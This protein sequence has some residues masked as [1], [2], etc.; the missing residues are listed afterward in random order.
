MLFTESTA[1]DTRL[2]IISADISVSLTHTLKQHIESQTSPC[3]IEI[4]S[5]SQTRNGAAY[6]GAVI[7]VDFPIRNGVP[8][9]VI[10]SCD[11][12][13]YQIA[14]LNHASEL[15]LIFID[16]ISIFLTRGNTE[17]PVAIN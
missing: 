6:D 3:N 15:H 17:T 16:I 13:I 2:S 7:R 5:I 4:Q 9:L 14:G 1:L 8:V 10:A 12:F 11:I